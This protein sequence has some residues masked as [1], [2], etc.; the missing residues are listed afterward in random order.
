VAPQA[1]WQI[2]NARAG[3]VP[4]AAVIVRD[5]RGESAP[6]FDPN[7][8]PPPQGTIRRLEGISKSFLNR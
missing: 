2:Q 7:S 1:S 6:T 5:Q 8:L 4:R 3:D